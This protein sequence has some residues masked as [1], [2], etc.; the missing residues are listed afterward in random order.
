M[1]MMKLDEFLMSSEFQRFQDEALRAEAIR[2]VEKIR[3]IAVNVK[4]HQ[5]HGIQGVIQGAGLKG[6]MELAEKQ[7]N[8]N[9]KAAN[10]AFWSEIDGLMSKTMASDI[11]LFRFMKNV[12][13][14]TGCIENEEAIGDK[15]EQKQARKRNH[16]IVDMALE[17]V[18]S[19]YFEHFTCHYFY[20]HIEGGAR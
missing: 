14:E 4:R 8:K 20:Q 12:L 18:I 2:A 19:A 11:S 7:K 16:Q 17:K 5:L 10:K 9:T 13:L 3:N 15:K 6:L 1:I